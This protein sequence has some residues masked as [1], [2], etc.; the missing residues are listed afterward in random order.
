MVS[1]IKQNIRALLGS[2]RAQVEQQ[3]PTTSLARHLCAMHKPYNSMW[4]PGSFSK[5]RAYEFIFFGSGNAGSEIAWIISFPLQDLITEFQSVF[6]TA[7]AITTIITIYR[8][9]TTY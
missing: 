7:I 1:Y 2:I 9:P 4:Q 3:P 6:L 5:L 8:V